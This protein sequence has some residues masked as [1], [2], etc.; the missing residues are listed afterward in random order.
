MMKKRVIIILFLSVLIL[1]CLVCPAAGW[2]TV[3]S[4]G[5]VV[6]E[7]RAVSD[8]TGVNL[9]TFGN[10]YIEQGDQES[11]RIEAEE[12]V[13]PYLETEISGHVLEIRGRGDLFMFHTRPVNFYLTVKK[14][15]KIALSGSGDVKAPALTGERLSMNVNGSGEVKIGE[16][17]FDKLELHIAG[18]GH[19]TIAE[20]DVNLQQIVVS[21]SGDYEARGLASDR[22][23]V[24]VSGSGSADLQARDYLAV[25]V[26]GSG[27]VYY[28]GSPTVEQ[29]IVGS[30]QI[31]PMTILAPVR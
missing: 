20:G 22:A 7:E 19:V 25:M 9:A 10:L 27:D 18:S 4:S 16:L 5:R 28:T 23:E 29:A 1:G 21:G 26:S 8:F 3:R 15:D 13:L 11:L 17:D 30:G 12:S 14:L 2:A 6:E 31:R 24:Y